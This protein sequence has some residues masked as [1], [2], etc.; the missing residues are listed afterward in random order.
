MDKNKLNKCRVSR[1][2]IAL[3]IL[4]LVLIMLSVSEVA[5]AQK[6]KNYAVSL[7]KQCYPDERIIDSTE[8]VLLGKD[9][10][11]AGA[12]VWLT[13][14]IEIHFIM[15][16]EKVSERFSELIIDDAQCIEKGVKR[17]CSCPAI[18]IGKTM[19]TE[20]ESSSN[21]VVIEEDESTAKKSLKKINLNQLKNY[22]GKTVR[23]EMKDGVVHEKAVITAIEGNQI[24]IT[25]FKYGGQI[26][27]NASIDEIKNVL[28]K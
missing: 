12:K 7:A 16:G 9:K 19:Q 25:E 5:W 23:I 2:S 4:L 21:N 14:G 17:P 27:Y 6:M 8:S 24:S 1:K 10:V 22:I 3:S 18:T 26:S 13:N 20:N 11:T 28:S 15:H